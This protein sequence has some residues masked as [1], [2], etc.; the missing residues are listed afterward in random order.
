MVERQPSRLDRVFGALADPTR[1]AILRELAARPRNVGELTTPRPMSLAA[2]SKHVKVLERAG[3]VT[4]TAEGRMRLCALDARPLRAAVTWLQ[5]YER[6][7]NDRLDVL[8]ALLEADP[9]GDAPIAG[10]HD[11]PVKE[12][13]K[14]RPSKKEIA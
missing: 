13:R 6:F 4:Q 11:G 8:A 10:P 2:V 1:R 5:H 7:W 14:K 9:P 3:L 12:R